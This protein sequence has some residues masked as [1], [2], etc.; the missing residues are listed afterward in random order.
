M[1]L[2]L[3]LQKIKPIETK[4]QTQISELLSTKMDDEKNSRKS[5]KPRPELLVPFGAE[6]VMETIDPGLVNSSEDEEDSTSKEAG[7][8]KAP[9]LVAMEYVDKTKVAP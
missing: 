8:Y 1:E 6:N 2:K 5:L 9:K 4:L 3:L 7:V